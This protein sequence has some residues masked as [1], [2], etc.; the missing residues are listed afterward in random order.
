M[1]WITFKLGR[2]G[3]EYE[4]TA[5]G[6]PAAISIDEQNVRV[7]HTNI[8][9]DLR[10][11]T[12]KLYVP[13]IRINS[14]YLPFSDRNI[15]ASMLNMTDT[16][17]SF[18]ARDDYKIVNERAIPTSTTSVLIANSSILLLDQALVAAGASG[19]IVPISVYNNVAGTGTNYYTGGSYAPATGTIT[20]GTPVAD[21]SLPVYVTYTYEGWLVEMDSMSDSGRGGR[22]DL[23][24]YDIV[25][26]GA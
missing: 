13:T 16:F 12:L 11:S 20:L 7:L 22:V 21:A 3:S 15:I 24:D 23:H 25:L 6:N 18:R 1:G 14:S 9:G 4:F 8:E 19:H 2:P 26:R 10:K 5:P 17:L